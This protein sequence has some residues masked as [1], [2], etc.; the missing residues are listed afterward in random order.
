M[1]SSIPVMIIGIYFLF[2]IEANQT[3]WQYYEQMY[4][5]V[6]KMDIRTIRSYIHFYITQM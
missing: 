1:T 6:S 3:G 2:I 4:A 5:I